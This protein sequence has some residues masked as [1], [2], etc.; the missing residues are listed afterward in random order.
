MTEQSDTAIRCSTLDVRRSNLFPEPD[1]SLQFLFLEPFYGGSH[2]DFADGLTANSRH[3][4]RLVTLPD[5]FWKW[6]MRGAAIYWSNR[7]KNPS[8]YDG[9]IASSMVSL[10]DLKALWGDQCP[11]M[12]A[13][14]HENQLTYPSAPDNRHDH[15]PGFTNITTALA[16]QRI[17]FNSRTH[18]DAFLTALP[19]FIRIMPDFR[20]KWV[21]DA[22]EKK[23]AV[24]YPGC[25]FSDPCPIKP[26]DKD[27]PPLIIW[28]HRWEH[29]KNPDAFFQ[30]LESITRRGID[31][32]VALLGESFARMP[33]IF[34]K[35]P[36]ILGDRMVQYGYVKSRH[37]Y[38]QWLDRGH[39]VISTALQENFGIAVIEA[40]RHGCLPLLPERLSYPEILPRAL[41]A[42]Y[43]YAD[44]NE[45]EHKLAL[46]LTRPGRFEEQRKRLSEAMAHYSWTRR[47]DQFDAEL[48]QLANPNDNA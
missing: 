44:Q 47:I 14:F 29:D 27:Q 30:V 32:Q 28:N 19:Q 2:R 45:L 6:R 40:M 15:Q 4:I 43:N 5:R 17:L 42:E 7:I 20:P 3:H 16:A 23:C 46:L 24:A 35:A 22:I 12:L 11:P 48:E 36:G 33:E 38:R 10:A 1:I 39:I 31:F 18:M 9:L 25:H 21:A 41:H 8:Q 34:E 37:E 26:R 13:Y